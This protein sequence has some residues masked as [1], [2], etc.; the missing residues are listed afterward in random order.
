MLVQSVYYSGLSYGSKENLLKFLQK[1]SNRLLLD[2][3]RI[4]DYLLDS[5]SIL[6]VNGCMSSLKVSPFLAQSS[7][8]SSLTAMATNG[9]KTFSINAELSPISHR[10]YWGCRCLMVPAGFVQYCFLAF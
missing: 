7:S 3:S 10:C 4:H 9:E 5:P 2:I 6:S 1:V 8:A